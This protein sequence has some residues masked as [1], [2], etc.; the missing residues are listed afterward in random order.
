MSDTQNPI[1]IERK[2]TLKNDNWKAWS[3]KTIEMVQGY[4]TGDTCPVTFDGL[5]LRIGQFTIKPEEHFVNILPELLVTGTENISPQLCA[6]RIRSENGLYKL[7]IKKR[8]DSNSCH[9]M[10]YLIPEGIGRYHLERTDCK[11]LKTRYLVNFGCFIVANA[12]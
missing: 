11:L 6:V 9:E 8:I 2:F 10:E 4:F 5:H 12:D 7:T 3:Y 1:E